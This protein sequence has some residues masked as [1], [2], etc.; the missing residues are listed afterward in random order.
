MIG[1]AEGADQWELSGTVLYV[2]D[3]PLVAKSHKELL[4]SAGLKVT[5]F[6]DGLEAIAAIKRGLDYDLALIDKGL[7]SRSGGT[8]S[9]VSKQ[10]HPEIAVIGMSGNCR[11]LPHS[12]E[13][14]EK[15][16]KLS[17]LVETITRYLRKEVL[18]AFAAAA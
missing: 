15:P 9:R 4:E 6:G 10:E 1:Y 17:H 11:P 2:E 7:P 8:V 18:P 5:L 14:I 3:E 16:A 13:H 12:D